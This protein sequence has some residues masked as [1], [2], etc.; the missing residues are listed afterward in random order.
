[1]KV[2][3]C[4][5]ILAHYY[6]IIQDHVRKQTELVESEI[7]SNISAISQALHVEEYDWNNSSEGFDNW[8]VRKADGGE[9]PESAKNELL[10]LWKLLNEADEE[11]KAVYYAC[12]Q[13]KKR[14]D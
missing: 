3:S 8:I 10:R 11:W 12:K 1:M 6:H 4:E 7:H 9:F 14:L 13:M 2:Y 5:E